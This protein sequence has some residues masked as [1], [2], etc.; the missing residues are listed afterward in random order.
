[1]TTTKTCLRCSKIFE[2]NSNRQKYCTADCRL[3][4]T[5]CAGCGEEFQRT[6]GGGTKQR[7]CSTTCYYGTEARTRNRTCEL[8]GAECEPGNRFCSYACANEAARA[9][10]AKT[11]CQHCGTEFTAKASLKRKYCS[12]SCSS[13]A[14]NAAPGA[15][16]PIGTTRMEGGGYIMIKTEGGWQQQH[17]QVMEEAL[18]R[19]LHPRERIHHRNGVRHDNRPENLELWHMKKK[20]PAGIRAADYHCHG[21]RC[22]E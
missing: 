19:P 2:A 13:R 3:G 5:Q 17:R 18:G 1:M 12:R 6:A 22:G 14:R 8:C 7:F 4:T 11:V 10:R 16:V 20:D 9:V 15:I 21:C